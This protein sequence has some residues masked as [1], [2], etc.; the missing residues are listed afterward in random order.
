MKIIYILL[1]IQIIAGSSTRAR[2]G[3]PEQPARMAP[4][5]LARRDRPAHLIDIVECLF[6]REVLNKAHFKRHCGTKKHKE[7]EVNYYFEQLPL[8]FYDL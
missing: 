7:N 5:L 1:Y 3:R 6:C 8:N 2:L 4:D